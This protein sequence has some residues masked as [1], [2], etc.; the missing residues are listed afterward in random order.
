MRFCEV[1]AQ[2]VLGIFDQCRRYKIAVKI[3]GVPRNKFCTVEPGDQELILE[4]MREV[5]HAVQPP[6]KAEFGG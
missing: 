2:D 1:G 6:I 4:D 3:V 5:L